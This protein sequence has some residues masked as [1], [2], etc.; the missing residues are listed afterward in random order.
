M[1]GTTPLF[2]AGTH[3]N[4]LSAFTAKNLQGAATA[5]A[6]ATQQQK[7]ATESQ[8]LRARYRELLP[9]T[10]KTLF[11]E[12]RLLRRNFHKRAKNSRK[13]ARKGARIKQKRLSRQLTWCEE[14]KNLVPRVG[15]AALD[16]RSSAAAQPTLPSSFRLMSWLTSAANSY[17]SSLNTSAQNPLMITPT[18]S[19][20]DTPR[21]W[22]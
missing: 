12:M 1:A 15:D 10:S 21:C 5:Q 14:H 8:P 16:G 11:S 13:K 18:A 9:A 22:K 4:A 7:M 6:A 19:S 17:G 20:G 3:L 2:T